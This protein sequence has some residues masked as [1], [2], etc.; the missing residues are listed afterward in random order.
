[1]RV[2]S[3]FSRRILCGVLAIILSFSI[4][5]AA[6]AESVPQRTVLY[7]GTFTLHIPDGTTVEK[8]FFYS[9]NYFSRSGTLSDPHMKTTSAAISFSLCDMAEENGVEDSILKKIGFSDIEMIDMDHYAKDSIG[10]V[11][12]QK[13]IK[14]HTAVAVMLRGYDYD[15]EWASN[16]TASSEGD[17]KGFKDAAALVE[18]RLSAYLSKHHIDSAKIWMTGYSRSA[19]IANLVGKDLNE[20]PQNYFTSVDDIYVY[21]FEAPASCADETI[22]ENIHNV[23][24]S[25]DLIPYFYPQGW[26]LYRCGVTEPIGDAQKTIMA[27]KFFLFSENLMTDFDTVNLSDFLSDF[28]NH[29]SQHISRQTYTEEMQDYICYMIDRY[30]SFNDEEKEIFSAFMEQ[31]SANLLM[32]ENLSNVIIGLVLNGSKDSSYEALAYLI[33]SN[34]DKTAI[35]VDS[36]FSDDELSYIEEGVHSIILACKPAIQADLNTKKVK[37]GKTVTVPL[38]YLLTLLGNIEEIIPYHYNITVFDQLVSADSYY[39]DIQL[40]RIGDADADRKISILDATAIQKHLAQISRLGQ[41][42]LEVAD[43]D[44]DQ[45]VSVLD[46]TYIQKYLAGMENPYLVNAYL[47]E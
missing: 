26:G 2:F 13:R 35:L 1:M 29:L 37:D 47:D 8:D 14:D 34:L 43:V 19:A 20:S 36:P 4:A 21:T 42:S 7:N 46:A 10:T 28:M 22:C 39:S 25:S 11:L 24:D 33:N 40:R 38:Y 12:A 45:V 16:F 9:D 44:D 17:I 32:D 31:F 3:A 18:E 15:N 6:F 23:I 41:D 30:Y 5:T 27:K